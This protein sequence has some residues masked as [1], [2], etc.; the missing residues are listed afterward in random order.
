[1]LILFGILGFLSR[2]VGGWG[3]KQV[4]VLME[5]ELANEKRVLGVLTNQRRVFITW[6]LLVTEASCIEAA[7]TRWG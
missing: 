4:L 2:R 7:V 1:M 3:L 5:S 6:R